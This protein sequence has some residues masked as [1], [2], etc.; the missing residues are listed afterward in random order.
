[1]VRTLH[2]SE[3]QIARTRPVEV[4]PRLL[5]T[6]VDNVYASERWYVIDTGHIVGIFADQTEVSCN[7]IHRLEGHGRVATTREQA[8][9]LAQRI[10][11]PFYINETILGERNFDR[12]TTPHPRYPLFDDSGDLDDDDPPAG[13]LRI[14]I[15]PPRSP[16]LTPYDDLENDENV[17]PP[18]TDVLRGPT[19]PS[20]AASAPPS[21]PRATCYNLVHT[22]TGRTEA[23]FIRHGSGGTSLLIG[24][25]TIQDPHE[26]LEV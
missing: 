13:D 17:P 16:S 8:R 24:D 20:P 19:L 7:T 15:P 14:P 25:G 10:T 22:G 11:R 26:I 12:P 6:V 1:M 3:A 4:V 2:D 21:P 9:Q 5:R 23:M 18:T